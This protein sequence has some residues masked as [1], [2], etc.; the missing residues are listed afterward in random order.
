MWAWLN[1]TSSSTTNCL[2]VTSRYFTQTVTTLITQTTPHGTQIAHYCRTLKGGSRPL[3]SRGRLPQ[4]YRCGRCSR[5]CL[6]Q[7]GTA[8]SI[9]NTCH[10]T[11]KWVCWST[12]VSQGGDPTSGEFADPAT[13]CPPAEGWPPSGGSWGWV[14]TGPA[15]SVAID[16]NSPMDSTCSPTGILE[17]MVVVVTEAE[18]LCSKS[19]GSTSLRALALV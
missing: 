9:G 17:A 11:I 18:S 3:G 15:I 2:P 1:S 10:S 16:S 7:I 4:S 12:G 14:A 13:P 19:S 6:S 8:L 5:S